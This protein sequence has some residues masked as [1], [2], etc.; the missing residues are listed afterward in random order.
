MNRRWDILQSNQGAGRFF[1]F[2]LGGADGGRPPNVLRLMFNPAGLRPY[3]TNWEA[4]AEALVQRV[5]R[6]AVSGVKDP[7]TVK[8]LD[9]VF[10]YPGVPARLRRPNLQ[11]PLIPVV[12]VRFRKDGWAFNFFS[13]VTTLG[14]PQDI[15]LQELRI[16]CFFPGDDETE[17]R[18]RALEAATLSSPAA[19]AST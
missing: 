6:E 18:A 13:T 15:T 1:S 14:T 4:V 5:H 2:L 16:E 11:D 17:A 8:L 10:A 19:S 9:E 7:A 12:A 3:V